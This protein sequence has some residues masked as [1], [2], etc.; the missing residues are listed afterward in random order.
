VCQ[1]TGSGTRF[2]LPGPMVDEPLAQFDWAQPNGLFF[3]PNNVGS[4]TACEWG[5]SLVP[6][7]AIHAVN[8]GVVWVALNLLFPPG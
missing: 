6:C 7:I 3:T 2:T 1:I 4:S 5:Q 8:N